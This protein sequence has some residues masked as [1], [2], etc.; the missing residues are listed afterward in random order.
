MR[1]QIAAWSADYVNQFSSAADINLVEFTGAGSSASWSVASG[2][3]MTSTNS[4]EANIPGGSKCT[5]Q[6]SVLGNGSPMD[7]TVS[8][9]GT[10]RQPV[11]TT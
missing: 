8:T 5:S 4:G 9:R 6:W 1:G 10:F 3:L 2:A 11:T 7:A